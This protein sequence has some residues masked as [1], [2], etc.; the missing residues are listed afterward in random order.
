MD[1]LGFFAFRTA[2]PFGYLAFAIGFIAV[3]VAGLRW[4][5]RG[6]MATPP[7]GVRVAAGAFILVGAGVFFVANVAYSAALD[8][9]PY[10]H[11]AQVTGE[12][13]DGPAPLTLGAKGDYD[14]RGGDACTGLCNSGRWRLDESASTLELE[15]PD[16]HWVRQRIV[17]YAGALRLTD[18]ILD[19]DMWDGRLTFRHLVRPGS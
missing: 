13:S 12:W 6:L 11:A 8:L 3:V 17:R 5:I 15:C 10:P 18:P 16:G 14:C 4:L 19:P 2:I 1:F 9:N 7:D